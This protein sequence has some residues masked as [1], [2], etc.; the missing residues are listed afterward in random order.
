MPRL[1]PPLPLAG[2]IA[3]MLISGVALGGCRWHFGPEDKGPDDPSGWEI[4]KWWTG[5]ANERAEPD[6]F[7]TSGPWGLEWEMTLRGDASSFSRLTVELL[8]AQGRRVDAPVDTD[9]AGCGVKRYEPGSYRLRIQS[10]G[11]G[12]RNWSVSWRVAVREKS[13][14]R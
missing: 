4:T 10:K 2:V 5:H 12:V 3:A 6:A 1:A 13:A 8:D 9:K 11:S 7:T 14:K